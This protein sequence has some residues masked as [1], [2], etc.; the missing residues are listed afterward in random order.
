MMAAPQIAIAEPVIWNALGY[1]F[2]AAP[3]LASL[4]ACLSVRVW[5]CL[6]DAPDTLRAR[7]IDLTVTGIALLFSGAWVVLQRPSPFFALLSGCGFGALG[8][9]IIAVSLKWVKRLTPLA[10]E[11]VVARS[12]TEG[13]AIHQIE[14]VRTTARRAQHS[15]HRRKH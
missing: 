2:E 5:I 14:R 8:T 1:P 10:D 15:R 3:M 9:G 7:A 13:A 12:T 4:A 6:K 11:D